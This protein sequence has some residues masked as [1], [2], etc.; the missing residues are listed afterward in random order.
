M[1]QQYIQNNH[2]LN[3]TGTR[4]F[5][6]YSFTCAKCDKHFWVY[7]KRQT[8]IGLTDLTIK[9]LVYANLY[10]FKNDK[11]IKCKFNQNKKLITHKMPNCPYTEDEVT[12][13]NIIK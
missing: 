13:K 7:D 12:V 11:I 9:V 10:Y 8:V 4:G 6:L 5:Y 2:I 1:K 3:L